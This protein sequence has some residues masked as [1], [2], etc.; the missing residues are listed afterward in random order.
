MGRKYTYSREIS[1]IEGKET[2]TAVEFDNFDEAVRIVDKG[3]YDRTLE[4][5]GRSVGEDS[6]VARARP[7]SVPAGIENTYVGNASN[8]NPL[9]LNTEKK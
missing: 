4:L 8:G 5:K 9:N 1:T 7:T 6:E 2:F 3:I